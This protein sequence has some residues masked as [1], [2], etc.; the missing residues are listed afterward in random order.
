M[1]T[2]IITHPSPYTVPETLD[3]LESLL[4]AKNIKVFT[5]VD[6]SGEAEKAGLQMPPTQ[7]L[8]FGNPKGGTPI[9]LAA[10]LS[11]IDL[12]IKALAWQD[13]EGKV[14]LSY[15]DPQYL[16]T[17]FSLPDELLAPITGLSAVIEQAL[18]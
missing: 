8:I 16:K 17:R 12:P 2:G 9:M 13:A 14:W 10:P 18:T 7:L 5:R 4:Q 11:A 15:N 1:A 6:H 3:R